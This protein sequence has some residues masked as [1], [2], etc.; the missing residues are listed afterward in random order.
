MHPGL[1]FHVFCKILKKK[2]EERQIVFPLK[3]KVGGG[4]PLRAI[5][6]FIV[7]HCSS[8]NLNFQVVYTLQ[9]SLLD[10]MNINPF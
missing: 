5:L 6:C 8:W 4:G 7:P 3:D 9:L 10:S 2:L 1:I